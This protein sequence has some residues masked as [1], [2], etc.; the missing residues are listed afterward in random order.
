MINCKSTKGMLRNHCAECNK[1]HAVKSMLASH[2]FIIACY[3]W[4]L[5]GTI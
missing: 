4:I 3:F 5:I 1:I 2:V